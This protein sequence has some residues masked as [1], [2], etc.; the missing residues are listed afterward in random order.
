VD[1]LVGREGA[2]PIAAGR[3]AH[4]RRSR[5]QPRLLAAFAVV[6]AG[7]A[8][9]STLVL[10][11]DDAA[12]SRPATGEQVAAHQFVPPPAAT[13]APAEPQV[14]SAEQ[15]AALPSAAA[16]TPTR[17][18]TTRAP[19]PTDPLQPTRSP[20]RESSQRTEDLEVTE[21]ID[22]L[23]AQLVERTP[24]LRGGKV[25]DRGSDARRRGPKRDPREE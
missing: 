15:I 22:E 11:S 18:R 6:S 2:A 16:P 12:P 5:R 3:R 21:E 10:M 4:R 17:P 7:A 8:G 24:D 23:A 13:P 20:E 9:A 14:V 19:T 25:R 1:V